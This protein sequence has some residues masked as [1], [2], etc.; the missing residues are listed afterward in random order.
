MKF[1]V[2]THKNYRETGRSAGMT[3]EQA[4][5]LARRINRSNQDH[6]HSAENAYVE[7]TQTVKHLPVTV[8]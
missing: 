7:E 8:K 5:A 1:S 4:L 6:T 2:V 3:F